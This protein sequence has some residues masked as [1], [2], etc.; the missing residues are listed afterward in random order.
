MVLGNI[1]RFH[2]T[3]ELWPLKASQIEERAYYEVYTGQA[4]RG[5]ASSARMGRSFPENRMLGGAPRD[6][7]F[8]DL[9]THVAS[10]FALCLKSVDVVH[11]RPAH[12]H[13]GQR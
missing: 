11:R 10:H 8:G 9:I 3:A 6:I 2:V 12:R 4:S 7:V 1:S 5:S 13:T